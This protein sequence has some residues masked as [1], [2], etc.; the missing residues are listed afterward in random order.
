MGRAE[1]VVRQVWEL[2][3]CIPSTELVPV[4]PR[5]RDAFLSVIVTLDKWYKELNIAAVN[6]FIL[7]VTASNGIQ[8]LKIKECRGDLKYYAYCH[9]ILGDP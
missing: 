7:P 3:Y 6:Y 4:P 9:K 5:F 2:T 8:N 1:D